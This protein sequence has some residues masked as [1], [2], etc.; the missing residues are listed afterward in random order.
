MALAKSRETLKNLQTSTEYKSLQEAED[1]LAQ[2]ESR[3]KQA[4]RLAQGAEKSGQEAKSRK[5]NAQT[6]I[7]RYQSELPP[8]EAE[9]S[10]REDAYKTA[11]KQ[12]N[13]TEAEWMDLTEK[14]ARTEPE[15]LQKKIDDHN[16]K[17]ASAQSR[18]DA[19]K[20]TVGRGKCPV[21]EELEAQRLSLIHI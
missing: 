5:E 19:A 21:L 9:S 6:L 11:M 20:K 8:K 14:Y 12:K 3:K 13:Q 17:K 1:T 7:S 16:R 10:E 15:L 4:E 18:I 2:A